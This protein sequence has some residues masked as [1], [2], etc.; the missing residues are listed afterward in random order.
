MFLCTTFLNVL[1]LA[2]AIKYPEIPKIRLLPPVQPVSPAILE[3]T[4]RAAR[5][6]L[7][8]MNIVRR[9]ADL[10]LVFNL[11]TLINLKIEE[12][13]SRQQMVMSFNSMAWAHST[14]MAPLEM[15]RVQGD[16]ALLVVNAA[17]RLQDRYVAIKGAWKSCLSHSCVNS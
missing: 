7:L 14:N 12:N 11:I 13:L 5:T 2:T 1:L 16:R 6:D 3:Q 15:A 9:Y 4:S 10:I 17:R 8:H